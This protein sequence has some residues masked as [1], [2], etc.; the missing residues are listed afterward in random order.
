MTLFLLIGNLQFIQGIYN[1]GKSSLLIVFGLTTIIA[2]FI[3]KLN[4]NSKENLSTTVN[5]FEQTQARLIANTAVEVYLEKLYDDPTLINTTSSPQSLFN[6]SYVVNLAGTLPNVRVTSTATFLGI[7]HI[8]VADAFLE[9]ITFPNMPGGMYISADAVV[10]AT[11]VGNMHIDGLDHKP[12]GTLK[13]N[14]KPAVW[15]VGVDTEGQK[16][17]ILAGLKKPENIKGLI[18]EATGETGYPSVGV[19][20]LGL[21]WA[22]IYQYLANAADQTFIQDIPKGSDLGT[23]ATPKI[24]LVNAD[25]NPNKTIMINGD[26]GAGILVV[27]GNIKF[28]GNF[29]FKGI[30]LCYKNSDLSFESVGTNQVIGGIIVAGKNVSFK[31][32]G[33]MDV[34]YS[35]DVLDLIRANLKS[36]GFKILSWYE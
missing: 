15:G 13:G 32:A 4:S 23:L 16:N 29:A 33:T 30:I 8:S 2:F 6:G 9:P 11:E 22:K 5:M 1:M 3:L 10:S 31:L 36:N 25:A 7:Q 26:N 28:A 14:G 35:K 17:S 34:I 24:T 27:N 12:D 20:N 18:N 21:D 19:T